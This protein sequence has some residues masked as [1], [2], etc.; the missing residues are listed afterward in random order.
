M[1]PVLIVPV[2][3]RAELLYDMLESIDHPVEKLIVIDNGAHVSR[4]VVADINREHVADRFV[5]RFPSNLGVPVSWNLGMKAAPFAPWWMISNFDVAFP[6]GALAKFAELSHLGRIVVSGEEASWCVFTI[7]SEVVE[8]VGL[9]DEGIHPAYFEDL[10]YLRRC[11]AHGVDVHVSEIMANHRNSSTVS[12]GFN[13][14]NT[15]TFKAN[16]QRFKARQS[17]QDLTSGEWSLA[18]RKALT[19]D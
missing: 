9:F 13:D 15:V 6:P 12:A 2:L 11:E 4:H 17:A 10:D 14:K 19:W 16:M 18:T 3:T 8:Q 1:I 7:G 5:W